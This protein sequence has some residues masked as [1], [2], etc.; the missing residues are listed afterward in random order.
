MAEIS[1]VLFLSHLSSM[2]NPS[3]WIFVVS[4]LWL[5]ILTSEVLEKRERP[6][7]SDVL[8]SLCLRSSHVLDSAYGI[9]RR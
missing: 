8:G 6:V 4:D 2:S 1:R 5:C 9:I 3:W 7:R